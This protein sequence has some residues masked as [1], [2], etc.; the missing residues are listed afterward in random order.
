MF[1]MPAFPSDVK[2]TGIT[3]AEI[4]GKSPKMIGKNA[5]RDD[6]GDTARERLIRIFTN[7]GHE[8]FGVTGAS[9]ESIE[10]NEISQALGVNPISL[11]NVENGITLY[12]LE[13]ALWD[14]IGK[15]VGKPVYALLGD[16]CRDTI[17]AYDGGLYFCDLVY[18]ELGLTR[19]EQ[20]AAESVAQGHRAIKM[21]IGRGNQWM[22]PEEGFQ[23]DVDAIRL[24]RRTIGPDIKLMLDGNNGFDCAG[25]ERLF[26]AVGDEDIYW[27]EEMFPE[28]IEDYTHFREFL[29]KQSPNTLIA[30]G[31]TLAEPSLLYPFIE[32]K[33]IDVVQLDMLQIG[34]SA[35]W[36]LAAFSHEH[37]RLSAPHTWSSRFAVYATAHL[38]K[39]IPNFLSDEIPAYAP[40]AYHPTGFKFH[41]GAYTISDMPGWGLELDKQVYEERYLSSERRYDY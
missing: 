2:I 21:K 27:A 28:T 19:V 25:A 3:Y 36:K 4:Y 10:K 20:E 30:D 14:L 23:R 32:Q 35:W 26:D 31:E 12:G 16:S 34:L 11:L 8:G 29:N 15:I 1:R 38:A 24:V 7:T 39:V 17:E 22:S 6:H 41:E 9:I 33:L 18:P 37:S 40:D 5:R 13:H